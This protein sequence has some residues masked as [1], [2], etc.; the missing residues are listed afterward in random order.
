MPLP[1]PAP[2]S[3][4]LQSQACKGPALGY[5]S[6]VELDPDLFCGSEFRDLEL[7]CT[8]YSNLNPRPASHGLWAVC[9]VIKGL[10]K[11]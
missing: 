9:L 7:H 1:P 10:I 3:L 8:G 11:I 6:A 2:W 5:Q 4:F